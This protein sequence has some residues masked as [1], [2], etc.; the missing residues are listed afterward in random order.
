[1]PK[2]S[3]KRE[4]WHLTLG[5]RKEMWDKLLMAALPVKVASGEFDLVHDMG[6]AADRLD[7]RSR[8]KGLLED[9]RPPEVIRRVQERAIALWRERRGQAKEL[10][11]EMVKV[12]GTWRV[13]IEQEGSEFFYAQQRV[14]LQARVSVRAEGMAYLVRNNLEFPF[15]LEK[16]A[17]AALALTDIHYDKGMQA[18][19]G[20]LGGLLVDLGDHVLYQFLGRAAEVGLEKQFPNVNP[21]KML[22]REQLEG[23]V[24]P[25]GGALRLNMGVEDLDLEVNVETV[26]LKVRFG[27]AQKQIE[28]EVEG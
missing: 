9:S 22:S 27:F 1:M 12:R 18:L 7:L 26:T 14:G 15:V 6:A 23:F 21:F 28:G 19:V 20:N 8:V 4:R 5:I 16:S 13:Q 2:K 17:S 11:H 25:A 10:V 3:K 24:S